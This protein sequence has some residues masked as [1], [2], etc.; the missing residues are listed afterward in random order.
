MTGDL[1]KMKLCIDSVSLILG[2]FLKI[3]YYPKNQQNRYYRPRLINIFFYW[4]FIHGIKIIFMRVRLCLLRLIFV[5]NVLWQY[6]HWRD[7]L[8]SLS[9]RVF[10]WLFCFLINIGIMSHEIANLGNSF[11][12]NITPHTIFWLI[13]VIY[14]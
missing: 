6:S 1:N 11:L 9:L 2:F 13:N 14:I 7:L 5:M 10:S 4:V 8:I 3:Y 12:P